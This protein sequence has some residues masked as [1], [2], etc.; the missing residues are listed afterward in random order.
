MRRHDRSTS[1]LPTREGAVPRPLPSLRAPISAPVGPIRRSNGVDLQRGEAFAVVPSIDSCVGAGLGGR[2]GESGA[3]GEAMTKGTSPGN[4]LL[5]GEESFDSTRLRVASA[6]STATARR[7]SASFNNSKPPIGR[8]VV[9]S[10]NI[11]AASTATP[12]I[13][14]KPVGSGLSQNKLLS[15]VQLMG[16]YSSLNKT[17]PLPSTPVLSSNK[18]RL[19]L[20]SSKKNISTSLSNTENKSS[21]S[22]F[23]AKVQS[24]TSNIQIKTFTYAHAPPPKLR[25]PKSRTLAALTN[26]TASLSRTSLV[27]DRKASASSKLGNNSPKAPTPSP[28]PSP[29]SLPDVLPRTPS[30]QDITSAHPSAYWAGRFLA[31]HDRFKSD[32]NLTEAP[33]RTLLAQAPARDAP[34]PG[35]MHSNTTAALTTLTAYQPGSVRSGIF[36]DGTASGLTDDE[37]IAI[38]V[39]TRL[40]ELCVTPEARESLREWQLAYAR[41]TGQSKLL[42]SGAA[43]RGPGG[44]RGDNIVARFLG[45]KSVGGRTEAQA[46]STQSEGVR[47]GKKK[48]ASIL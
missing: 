43:M 28:P 19:S 41:K 6:S 40:A 18:S 23:A 16:D 11:N 1:R 20:F 14:R 38:A 5:G 33:L 30:L 47:V 32:A 31:L 44:V 35:L 26:L 39:F 10:E 22:D 12:T 37:S 21:G 34:R 29:P 36:G 8:P 27:S 15:K 4:N 17:K 45:R 13:K 42:P 3:V 25:I 24:A 48:R 2:G 7:L 46:L 9:A